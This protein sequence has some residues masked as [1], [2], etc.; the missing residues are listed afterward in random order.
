M[1]RHSRYT[2]MIT[3]NPIPNVIPTPASQTFCSG[4]TTSIALTSNVPG[5]TFSWTV[6]QNGVNGASGGSGNSISQ[7]L[8]TSGNTPG[9]AIYSITPAFNGC[10]GNPVTVTVTVNPIPVVRLPL[11]H[12]AL[13]SGSTTSID[14][15]SNVTGTT[16]SWTIRAERCHRGF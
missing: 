14:L 6:A 8:T 15:T 10:N 11:L 7:T 5:A 16:F 3:V 12:C 13:C 1:Q 4:G 9:T 2:L